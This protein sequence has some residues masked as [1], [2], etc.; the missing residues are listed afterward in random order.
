[1]SADTLY[2]KWTMKDID[3]NPFELNM[4]S[5]NSDKILLLFWSAGC[6]HCVEM[7]NNLY[8]WQKQS[9]FQSEFMV[10]A[11]SLDE[12]E[13]ET[14]AWEKKIVELKGWK[15]LH[16]AEGVR[17]KVAS[18]YF[19]LATPVL[20]LLDAKTKQIVAA[21]SSLNELLAVIE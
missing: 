8:S 20:F 7:V 18:N 14:G 12:T 13:M 10:V 6:S 21:P 19:V 16:A 1:M 3:G 15:H 17:S 9:T 2:A 5:T 11:I 4:L